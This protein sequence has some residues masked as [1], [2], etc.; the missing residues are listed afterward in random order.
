MRRLFHR[1]LLCPSLLSAALALASGHTMAATAWV[2]NEKDNSLSLIDMQTLE[3]TDTLPVGQRPRGLLLSHD[4]KL[5]YICASDSDRVQVMDVATRTIIKELPSGK[6][7]EQFALHP[8]DRWLY[9]SN[10]DDALVT[11]I[12][13]VTD[14]VLG[15]IDVGIEPEGMAV[16]PDG[17]WAVNTSETTNMLHWICTSTQT[18]A[19]STLV[20][21]RPRFVEFNKDGSRLWAS[22]EIGGTVTI[23]DVAT[24]QVLKTLNFQIKGVHPDKVQPVGIKLSAD[25]KYAF[26]ALGPANHVAVI[27]ANTYEV[28][29]YL[30]VGRRVWQLAFTPDQSQL[31]ATNG[32]SGDVSVIDAKNLKVLKSVKVGRYPWGVVVTP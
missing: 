3:V 27:D 7:P 30:L 2:S 8:N 12:D 1:A 28:L 15:Q 21:Q 16:S 17:K 26:V 22:A 19:D 4:N 24:R 9:V 31:L 20:D 10:E 11:V 5:L 6:D 32:V 25:G 18:L 13:T 29:D 14:K 23:L